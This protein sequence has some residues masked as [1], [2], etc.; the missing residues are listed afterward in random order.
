MNLNTKDEIQKN[1]TTFF[2]NEYDE[3]DVKHGAR[4][5]MYRFLSEVERLSDEKNINRKELAKLIGTSP[6]YI[7]QLFKGIKLLNLETAAKFENVFNVKFDIKAYP[8]D[9]LIKEKIVYT[10]I[11]QINP[12]DIYYNYGTADLS[13]ITYP[14]N[15]K[16]I[17]T[18][19]SLS[20]AQTSGAVN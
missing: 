13:S 9:A 11:V 5:I 18:P 14:F 3:E 4:I 20:R 10:T 15:D 17:I 1:Y 8:K 16:I 7:T 12:S 6:S 2:V 19:F